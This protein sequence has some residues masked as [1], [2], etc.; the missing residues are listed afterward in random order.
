MEKED[1]YPLGSDRLF[2]GAENY[3]LYKTMV[4]H[5]QQGIEA[6]GDGKIDDEVT[7]DLLKGAQGMGLDWGKQRDCGMCVRLVLLACGTAFDILPYVLCETQP[8]KF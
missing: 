2:S 8:P 5:N 1:S 4:N 7:R 3:P 6:G